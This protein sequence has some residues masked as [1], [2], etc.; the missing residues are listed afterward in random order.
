LLAAVGWN[1]APQAKNLPV[2]TIDITRQ[3]RVT[4]GAWG[5]FAPLSQER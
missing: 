1:D 4:L 3:K 5:S 2:E